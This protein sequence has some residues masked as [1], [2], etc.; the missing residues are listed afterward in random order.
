[1]SYTE[2]PFVVTLKGDGNHA[3]PWIV[4]RG[5]TAEEVEARLRDVYK[6]GPAAIATAAAFS[7]EYKAENPGVSTP[8]PWDNP[9]VASAAQAVA[10]G[11]GGTLAAE[12]P[13]SPAPQGS[14]PQAQ[15]APGGVTVEEDK[16]GGRY[17]H[18]LPNAPQTQ[19]GP[20]VKKTAKAKSGKFY[21]RWIDPRDKSIPSVYA[22][23]QR[24]NPA[25]LWEGSFA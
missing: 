22:S 24:D 5:E 15:A 13:T 19:W 6:L 23:G 21:S 11:L 9:Q 14:A 10:A 2:A 7:N 8:A 25:D 18:N 17:E 3:A 20:A 1:M 16:W 4:V 12:F